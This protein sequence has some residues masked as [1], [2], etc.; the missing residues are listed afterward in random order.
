MSKDNLPLN[1]AYGVTP[2]GFVYKPYTVIVTDLITAFEAA[3]GVD[4]DTSADTPNGQMIGILA[5][6]IA[7]LWQQGNAVYDAYNPNEAVGISLRNIG[8]LNYLPEL[9][10]SQ[11]VVEVS[12]TFSGAQYIPAAVFQG[13]TTGMPNTFHL[14]SDLNALSAGTI[15]VQMQADEYGQILAPAGTLTV[16]NTP[17][18]NLVSITNAADATPGQNTETDPEYRIRRNNS[19]T[20]ASQ[21]TEDSLYT[22]LLAVDGV[23][24]AVVYSNPRSTTDSNG[25]APYSIAVVVEGGTDQDIGK[26][27]YG[28][29]TSS[30]P[31][32]GNIEVDIPNNANILVPIFFYRNQI[33]TVY[34]KIEV[35]MLEG[36]PVNG[37]S[38]IQKNTYDYLVGT[39]NGNVPVFKIGN[40]VIITK[41]YTPINLT[42]GVSVTALL[43][44]DVYPP[45]SSTNLPINFKQIAGFSLANIQVIAI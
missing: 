43:V 39:F 20:F 17:Y 15:T 44:D 42:P 28:R 6:A 16:I 5:G 14:V 11:S 34:I 24:D 18:S 1:I 36:F 12:F 22:A 31:T 21:N 33:V 35:E 40:S 30:I 3:Y 13:Q 4:L 29:K 19:T 27:I 45:I 26:A 2:T 9:K 8:V 37:L 7:E 32:N 38:Q 10:A 23:L 25:F 41:L